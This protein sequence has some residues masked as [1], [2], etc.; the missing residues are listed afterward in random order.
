[1]YIYI[2]V[3]MYIF[4]YVY[5]LIYMYICTY[6][7]IYHRVTCCS[8]LPNLQQLDDVLIP[9]RRIRVRAPPRQVY[10]GNFIIGGQNKNH[11]KKIEPS[12]PPI[13]KDGDIHRIN[14]DMHLSMTA[15][16]SSGSRRGSGFLPYKGSMERYIYTNI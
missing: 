11:I 12:S 6:M 3:Y 2:Y 13:S 7:Y 10:P 1:M 4:M 5:K 15:D 9:G 14:G 16:D 8:V